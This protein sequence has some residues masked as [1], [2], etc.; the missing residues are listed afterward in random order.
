M[1]RGVF[2]YLDSGYFFSGFAFGQACPEN[3]GMTGGVFFLF[4]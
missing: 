3:S 1:P 2:F 4:S